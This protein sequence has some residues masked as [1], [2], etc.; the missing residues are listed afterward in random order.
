MQGIQNLGGI[1][2]QLCIHCIFDADSHRFWTSRRPPLPTHKW[3]KLTSS[4]SYIFYSYFI[5]TS[6]LQGTVNNISFLSSAAQHK[7]CS[8]HTQEISRLCI[9]WAQHYDS[10]HSCMLQNQADRNCGSAEVREQPTVPCI[11][12]LQVEV[13]KDIQLQ[14][15]QVLP[16]LCRFSLVLEETK[17]SGLCS[18]QHKYHLL[19]LRFLCSLQSYHLT[20]HSGCEAK[21]LN[22]LL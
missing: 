20:I 21:P 5:V 1:L 19:L 8:K 22:V 9:K 11:S 3:N 2:E 18:S 17:G 4:F 15:H 6:V 14:L 7:A 16:Q 10:T 12:D 13:T